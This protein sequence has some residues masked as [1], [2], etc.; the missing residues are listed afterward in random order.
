M[1]AEERSEEVLLAIVLVR[2]MRR[3]QISSHLAL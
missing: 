2:L 1:L 3:G